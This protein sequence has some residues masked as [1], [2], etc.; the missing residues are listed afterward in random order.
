LV[1][2]ELRTS[3]VVRSVPG[4]D[5]VYSDGTETNCTGS[6][7]ETMSNMRTIRPTFCAAKM[8]VAVFF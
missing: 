2:T 4:A 3:L 1:A 5:P 7:V 6:L 8:D